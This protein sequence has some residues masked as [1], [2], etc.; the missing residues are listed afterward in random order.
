MVY[1]GNILTDLLKK[2]AQNGCLKSRQKLL[3][4]SLSEIQDA[5]F[6]DIE[7]K[8][9]LVE[10]FEKILL[11]YKEYKDADIKAA[12]LLQGNVHARKGR[13]SDVEKFYIGEKIYNNH[14]T[15]IEGK[16][17]G[18]KRKKPLELCL[19]E[20]SKTYGLSILTLQ[21]YYKFYKLMSKALYDL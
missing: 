15:F 6:N 8:N 9:Y 5:N 19:E 18:R 17:K 11:E 4:K 10:A 7:I 12:L 21:D 20:A 2:E 13:F 14:N 1:V 16:T 3:E